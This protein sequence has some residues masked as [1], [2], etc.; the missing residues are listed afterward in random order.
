MHPLAA[1]I[2]LLTVVLMVV[3]MMLVARARGRHGIKA[4]ATS[5]HPDFDRVFRIQMNTLE[6]VVMFLPTFLVALAF[7]NNTIAI[8]LGAIWLIGRSIYVVGYHKAADKRAL[9]FFIAIIATA[10]LLLQGLWGIV[11]TMLLR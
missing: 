7:G 5:G 11:W 6:Q 3:T 9:G 1:L 10:L 8:V 2:V 4:P